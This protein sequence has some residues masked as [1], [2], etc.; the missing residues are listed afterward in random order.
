MYAIGV[1]WGGIHDR[2]ALERRR[3]DRRHAGGAP[4]RPLRPR[5]RRGAARAA[6]P[7]AARVPRPRR[8][9]ASTTPTYDRAYDELVALEQAHPELVT[10][11]SPTQRVGAP[12][13]DRFPKVQHLEPMGS[14]EKVT[15]DE[16]VEKWA[17]DVRKRLDSDEPGRVRDRAEDRRARDQPHLRE[18]GARARRDARRREVRARTS[19]STC[20]RSAPIPL[21][22]LGD[23]V[24]RAARG[25]RRG[26]PA[27]L[28]LPRAERAARRHEAEARAEPAQRR[29]R[30]AAP[31]GL[32]I[33]AS[34]PLAV[35]VYGIGAQRGAGARART[36][37]RSRGCAST[38]SA[39]IRSPSALETIEAV[40][41]A[42]RDWER[43][44]TELDYEIDGIV[45]KVDSLAQQAALGALHSRP[46]WARAF[47]WAPMTAQTKLEQ[48]AIR[49]GR[50]GALNPWAVLEP[51]EV[52]GVTVSRA[53]L[54][55]EED[56]NRK[57]HPRG[58]QRDRPARR[59]RDP[60]GRRA[61][62]RARAGHEASSGCR[63][64]ARSAA[65]RS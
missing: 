54:H 12:P 20:A 31:E 8:A 24:A 40:A 10:P 29:R 56:I 53:T 35:W 38:A 64:T 50:T 6:E 27:A 3:R 39:R 1:S 26:L 17:E 28:G 61:G 63:R 33:T 18:R 58:R 44:R 51:V 7:L 48:I 5:A 15:T 32:A 21:R 42:C 11:D 9:V 45:I 34:R 22:M 14:L 13:S 2:D 52:G 59:R 60:A 47:K 65:R 36:G 4:C 16:A 62:R 57:E 30:L 49:V 43:K 41:K 46:R 19:P 37:R 55:N 23:D 25:A